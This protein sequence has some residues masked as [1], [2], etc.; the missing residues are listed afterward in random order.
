MA[1]ELVFP[2]SAGPIVLRPRQVIK[3]EGVPLYFM[4]ESVN[5][6]RNG[7]QERGYQ[8]N[9]AE[10]LK[11]YVP[12]QPV[13]NAP[14]PGA[15]PPHAAQPG[16]QPAAPAAATPPP[17]TPPPAAPAPTPPPAAPAAP[18]QP[19]GQVPTGVVPGA[20]AARSDATP[21][22]EVPE[23]L[24]PQTNAEDAPKPIQGLSDAEIQDGLAI[25]KYTQDGEGNVFKNPG[26]DE[27]P[28]IAPNHTINPGAADGVSKE[29]LQQ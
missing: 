11:Y 29:D 24:A 27:G 23:H 16:A 2:T 22:G 18:A 10:A 15:V 3:V 26:F 14:L 8:M 12:I 28:A 6:V 17:A 25:G 21:P 1:K 5:E 19:S 4:L 13:H 20:E 9:E 7:R